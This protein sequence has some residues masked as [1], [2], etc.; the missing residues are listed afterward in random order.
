[1]ESV[2]DGTMVENDFDSPKHE[3]SM[4]SQKAPDVAQ[5]HER[6][7]REDMDN[8]G[9]YPHHSA[10]KEDDYAYN[11]YTDYEGDSEYYSDFE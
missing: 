10:K 5:V 7:T 8:L 9:G 2:F 4:N 1:M 6:Q 3:P 11:S